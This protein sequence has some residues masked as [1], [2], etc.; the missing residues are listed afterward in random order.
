MQLDGGQGEHSASLQ[1]VG[2]VLDALTEILT[3]VDPV[4]LDRLVG[5]LEE[6][7]KRCDA[8]SEAHRELGYPGFADYEREILLRV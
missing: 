3:S 7:R 5:G 1:D 4:A 6:K 8:L 2:H